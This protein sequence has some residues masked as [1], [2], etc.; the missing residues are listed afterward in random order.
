M[1]AWWVLAVTC[2]TSFSPALQ[3]GIVAIGFVCAVLAVVRPT[4][5]KEDWSYAVPW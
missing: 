3:G 2:L 4:A 5:W 1:V